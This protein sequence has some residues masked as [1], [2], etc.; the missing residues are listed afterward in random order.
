M[1]QDEFFSIQADNL[2]HRGREARS[3]AH[4]VFAQHWVLEGIQAFLYRP[5]TRV[6][7]I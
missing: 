2:L 6:T 3:L 4:D 5:P 1:A 7:L